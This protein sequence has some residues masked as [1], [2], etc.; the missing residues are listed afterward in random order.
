MLCICER[1]VF[2]EARRLVIFAPDAR[3][4]TPRQF[5]SPSWIEIPVMG[6]VL[7]KQKRCDSRRDI[8]GRRPILTG[9]GPR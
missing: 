2:I 4:L 7:K 9:C 1:A 5:E 3:A 8:E 6:I